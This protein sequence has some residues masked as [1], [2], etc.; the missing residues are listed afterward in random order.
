M[1]LGN[2]HQI[3]MRSKEIAISGICFESNYEGNFTGGQ[4]FFLLFQSTIELVDIHS[5]QKMKKEKNKDRCF[6]ELLFLLSNIHFV[7]FVSS[8]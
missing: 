3:I 1:C 2:F 4:T 6:G 7:P 5:K 8:R